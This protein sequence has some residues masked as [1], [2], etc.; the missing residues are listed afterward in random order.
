MFKQAITIAALVASVPAA[1]QCAWRW[2]CTGGQCR[3][4]PICRNAFDIV[5]IK[6]IEVPPIPTPSIRPI[7]TPTIPPIGT[8]QCVQR[9]IC[10]SGQCVW[11]QVCR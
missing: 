2:D 6:P 10:E 3:Q 4:V 1:A 8:R 5:P 9:Y 11:K 7:Q